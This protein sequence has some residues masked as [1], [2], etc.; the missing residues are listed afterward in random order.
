VYSAEALVQIIQ[1]AVGPVILISGQ[2]LLLLTMTN[3]LGRII[4]RSRALSCGMESLGSVPRE[5]VAQ[6]IDIL[7][8]R[9]RLIR[10]AIMLAS[11][12]CLFAALLVIVLFLSPLVLLDIPYL[13]SFL[14]IMSMISLIS[15]LLFF[16][17]DIQSS[18]SALRIEL[19]GHREGGEGGAL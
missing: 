17:F 11:L 16:L 18:L 9:G 10:S 5:R 6:E 13:I 15:S 19:D 14:F 3:R 1:T 4:D 2:G 8:K 7:W 12:S